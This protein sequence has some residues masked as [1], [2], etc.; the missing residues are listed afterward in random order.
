MTG[1]LDMNNNYI[2][3]VTS[4]F[5]PHHAANKS[6]V[7]NAI[8]SGGNI[9][10]QDA[11]TYTDTQTFTTFNNSVSYTNTQ[12]NSYV[13]INNVNQN[14]DG[15]KTFIKNVGIG[16]NAPSHQLHV[17]GSSMIQSTGNSGQMIMRN[18]TLLENSITSIVFKN[19]VLNQLSN[20]HQASIVSGHT[21]GGRTYIAFRTNNT[22]NS[23]VDIEALRIQH[24][25]TTSFNYGVTMNNNKISGLGAP[26]VNTDATTKFYVD[27]AISTIS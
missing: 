3:N 20:G 7:D 25:G 2:A 13:T 17:L 5:Q 4:P 16:T 11:N 6:Y 10:L 8:S 26:T 15:V 23:N 21:T 14:I 19:G 1:F 27:N 22:V 24:D 12:L 9:V 18:M